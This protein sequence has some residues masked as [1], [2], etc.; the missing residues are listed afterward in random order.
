L[1]LRIR[2]FF[3][4]L[5]TALLLKA[6]TNPGVVISQVSTA[7]IEIFNRSSQKVSIAGWS[8]QYTFG[9]YDVSGQVT[10]NAIAINGLLAPGQ[11]YLVEVDG[12][13]SLQPDASGAFPLSSIYGGPG[14]NSEGT[15][16]L[17]RS[18][19]PL[20]VAWPSI[21]DVAD[22]FGY[23]PRASGAT[24][25]ADGT[26]FPAQSTGSFTF[27]P[28]SALRLQGGCIDTHNNATD[29]Q[30]ATPVPRTTHSALASCPTTPVIQPSGI[31]NAASL[32]AGPVAPGELLTIF[33][34]NLG[35]TQTVST[36]SPADVA[37]GTTDLRGVRVLFDGVPA[38]MISASPGQVSVL[39]PSALAGE[40]QTTVQVEKNG[41][42]S[43]S[44][45]LAVAQAAPGIF[46]ST[47]TG[48]GQAAALNQDSTVNSVDFPD[49]QGSVVTIY[50]TGT[51][52][53]S[54]VGDGRRSLPKP[55]LPLTVT[56]GGQDANILLAADALGRQGVLQVNAQIPAGLTGRQEVILKV[57]SAQ[58]QP[59]VSVAVDLGA[60]VPA[61]YFHVDVPATD[62]AYDGGTNRLYAS[63][64]DDGSAHAN[65]VAVID[66]S[67][68][69]ILNWIQ[70]GTGAAKLALSDDG[71]YLYV[72]LHTSVLIDSIQR[73]DLASGIPDFTVDLADIYADQNLSQGDILQ[74][75]DMQVLPGQPR[76]LAIAVSEGDAA[77]WTAPASIIDDNVRRP[78]MGPPAKWL[79][80]ADAGL[81]W[82]DQR[83][84]FV[85]A[86]GLSA[87]PLYP[88]NVDT[89]P[90]AV[91][92]AGNLLISSAGLVMNRGGSDLVA[93]MAVGSVGSSLSYVYRPDTGLA[94]YAGSISGDT[95]FLLEAFDLGTY[96]PLGELFFYDYQ[97]PAGDDFYGTPQRLISVG[98]AGL[99]TISGGFAPVPRIFVFPLSAIRPLSP[100][101]VPPPSLNSSGIRRFAIPSN[102]MAVDSTGE[103]LYLSIPS[104]APPIGNSIL[105][106]DVQAG[107]FGTPVWVGSEPDASAVSTDGQHLH[108][109]L[110]GA[111]AIVRLSLPALNVEREFHVVREDGTLVDADVVLS[112]P[113]DPTSVVVGRDMWFLSH[114]FGVA[115]YD[116]G[117]QRPDTTPSYLSLIRQTPLVN[118]AQISADGSTLYGEYGEAEGATLS[119]WIVTPEGFQFDASGTGFGGQTYLDLNCE[120]PLCLTGSGYVASTSTLQLVTQL[121][122]YANDGLALLDLDN[123]RMF[124]LT[125]SGAD[126]DIECYDATTYRLTG[127]YVIPQWGSAHGFKQVVG[128][129]LAIANGDELILLPI[130]MLQPQ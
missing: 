105:P 17:V 73:I 99:A 56:V 75:W 42:L 86:E 16:A 32:T 102:S 18:V 44:Q 28:Q 121:G 50:A 96:M 78:A 116:D 76:S 67:S 69:N 63:I 1:K 19:A 98:P 120:G 48:A 30:L 14:L 39:A 84:Y 20:T 117:V 80:A 93:Q 26:A 68:G 22:L 13:N 62:I 85:G 123:N 94:Y 43:G 113:S 61:T 6:D 21:L 23:G 37:H 52:L 109:M 108:V 127:L 101:Q 8:V 91:A 88:V 70:T 65:S 45:T 122:N 103:H 74:V 31:V 40:S 126:T 128:N 55:V 77:A 54:S 29:F 110:D 92:P 4:L 107:T 27:G 71:R 46:T 125:Y 112:L 15:V 129:Q 5:V 35:P 97:V 24:A 111:R 119:R 11:Y 118:E 53:T 87:G 82:G 9:G 90:G 2:C 25:A 81:L 57:G 95:N 7:F 41:V 12:S 66:P 51:G 10:W 79:R 100:V 49:P 33:G 130:S 59:G 3:G 83:A 38:P 72:A 34:A 64:G 60:A 106:F 124:L 89:P 104:G 36:R 115:I 47:G 58:S 114:S